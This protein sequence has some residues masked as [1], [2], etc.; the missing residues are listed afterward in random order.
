MF[1]LTSPIVFAVIAMLDAVSADPGQC[2]PFREIY[3]DG[4]ALCETMWGTAFKYVDDAPRDGADDAS[5]PAFTMW[6]FDDDATHNPNTA[7][8]AKLGLGVDASGRADVCHLSYNHR[9]APGPEPSGDAHS[10]RECLPWKERACCKNTTV[11]SAAALRDAY[12]PEWRWD[13]CGA[14][15]PACE[16][17]FVR[18]ACFYECEPAAGFYRRFEG[19]AH[20]GTPHGDAHGPG[21]QDHNEWEMHGMPI[22]GSYCDAWHAACDNENDRFCAVDGGNFFSCAGEYKAHDKKPAGADKAVQQTGP[23]VVVVAVLAVVAALAL[24]LV[25]YAAHRERATG[26]PLFGEAL[27]PQAGAE[28][29]DGTTDGAAVTKAEHEM[30]RI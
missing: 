24:G 5:P 20:A 18:E 7:T 8:A 4:R 19:A 29:A 12:G 17:F 22:K 2:R 15:T 26:R 10:F 23:S 30:V 14:L 21:H 13:R 1:P 25:A 11:L 28:G 3:P 27:L 6:F 16:R 9:D